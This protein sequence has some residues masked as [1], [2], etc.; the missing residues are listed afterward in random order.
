MQELLAK[1]T[2]EPL[3]GGASFYSNVFVV[4]K[5]LGG[6]CH[7][8]SLEQFNHYMHISIL[9][10]LLLNRCGNL[11]IK[12][13]MLSPLILRMLTY[14]LLLFS[15]IVFIFGDLF[16]KISLNSGRF[17]HLGLLQPLGFSFLL[18]NPYC[19]FAKPK[20]LFHYLFG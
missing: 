18:L 12:V 5:H 14:I 3:T 10:C 11:F 1:G 4:P 15:I 17:C 16:G 7:I 8:L 9:R 6:L 2:N 13:I 20:V 19:S